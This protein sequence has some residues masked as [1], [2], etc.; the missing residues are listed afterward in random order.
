MI[1]ISDKEPD[2]E[3]EKVRT[4][5]DP[6]RKL[7]ASIRSYQQHNDKSCF[8]SKLLK[9]ISVMRYRFWSVITAADIP[10]TSS[11]GGG[12]IL[13]HPNGIVI[14]PKSKIGPNCLI[15]QQVTLGV[16]RGDEAA[17]VLAG[18]VDIGAGAKI[19]GNIYVGKH[20]LIGANAVVTKDV[21]DYAIVAGIPAKVIGTTKD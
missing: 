10:I 3:R 21:P 12:V 2:W 15:H 5:W 13:P 6:S 4:F 18:H 1:E 8:I 16:K 17:P 19:I 9:K 7:L 14:H 11:I 20:S